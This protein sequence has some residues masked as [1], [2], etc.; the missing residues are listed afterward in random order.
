[1]ADATFRHGTPRMTDYTPGS[2]VTGGSVVVVGDI[3]LIAHRDIAASEQGAMA[4]GGGV[5]EVTADA[6]LAAGIKVYWDDTANKVTATTTSNKVFGYLVD[7]TSAAA[8]G[9]LVNALHMP[10]AT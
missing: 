4:T 1:M 7:G 9:D 8:D 2:A 5:Y 10:E 6:A 3:A